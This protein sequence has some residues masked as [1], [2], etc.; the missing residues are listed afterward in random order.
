MLEDD[1][2]VTGSVNITLYD[3]EGQVLEELSNHN[4]VVSSGKTFIASRIAS[5]TSPIMNYIAIGSGSTAPN[6]SNTSLFIETGRI[7]A[8]SQSINNTVRFTCTFPESIGTGAITEAG[9]FN[10]SSNG[11]MLCRTVFPSITKGAEDTMAI[12][13]TLTIN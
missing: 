5:N 1:V 4:L 10:A 2:K 11:I 9:I 8:V 7:G 3:K 13:W 6:V 12:V